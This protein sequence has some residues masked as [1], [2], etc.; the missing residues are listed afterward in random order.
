M[1]TMTLK[2]PPA[3][4]V[5]SNQNASNQSEASKPRRLTNRKRKALVRQILTH[6]KKGRTE[7]TKASDLFQ[8]LAAGTAVGE[9]IELEDGR[10]QIVDNFDG[11]NDAFRVARVSRYE[12]K[13]VPAAAKPVKP[14]ATPDPEDALP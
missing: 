3:A 14:Q 13:K 10:F 2:A 11:T 6:Q 4:P 9:V 8:S 12:L 1:K 7:Y 5:T